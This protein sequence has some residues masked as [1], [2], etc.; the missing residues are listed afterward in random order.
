MR[1]QP[2]PDLAYAFRHMLTQEVAYESLPYATRSTLHERLG[3]FI[4]TTA[5][6]RLDQHLDQLAY[7]YAQGRNESKKKEYLLK[8]GRRAQH[9]YAN[10]AAIDYFSGHCLYSAMVKGQLSCWTW[11][12]YWSLVGQL[13]GSEDDAMNRLW[14]WLS[15]QNDP[16][17]QAWCETSIG[18][19]LTKARSICRRLNLAGWAQAGL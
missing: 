6:G 4:E 13:A 19:L 12:E 1:E 14:I 10:T 18:E 17:T 7:H 15:R 11:D 16:K 3:D 2:E 8:A 5:A 9:V